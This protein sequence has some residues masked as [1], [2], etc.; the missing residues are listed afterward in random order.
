VVAK[1]RL[2]R[3]SLIGGAGDLLPRLDVQ[4]TLDDQA[5]DVIAVSRVARHP[6]R[7]RVRLLDVAQLRQLSHLVPHRR[8]LHAE[9]VFLHEKLAT[10]RVRR[11][12]VLH[13][14]RVENRLFSG[15]EL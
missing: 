7:A 15:V 8:R 5:V 1:Q 6:A 3:A 2:K 9:V 14:D 11:R 12:D 10:H 4:V 13:H